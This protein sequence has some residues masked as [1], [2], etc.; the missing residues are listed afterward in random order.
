MGKR[1]NTA[2]W[3]EDQKRWRIKVQKNGKRKAFYSSIPGRNGQREANKKADEWL[4]FDI[5]YSTLKISSLWEDFLTEKKNITSF[6]NYRQIESLGRLYILPA[7]GN[8]K[9]SYLTEQHLQDIINSAWDKSKKDGKPFS[10]K[11]LNNLRN[12]IINFIKF[13]RK[14]S[15]TALF[16]EN[17]LIPF[18][19]ENKPKKILQKNDI[20]ILFTSD[21]TSYKGKEIVDPFINAYRFQVA[22]GLRPGELIALK[23]SDIENN[24][25]FLKRSI[26]FHGEF[27]NGK[28]KNAKRNFYLTNLDLKILEQQRKISQSEYIFD[29]PVLTT[30]KN[31]QKYY[32]DFWKRYQKYN[33]ITPV[34]PYELRHTFVSI[35]QNLPESEI[36]KIVGHSKN[37]DTFG[38]YAHNFNNKEKEISNKINNVFSDVLN[39]LQ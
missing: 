31:C 2:K 25:I 16:P 12:C 15:A 37:M 21:K 39:I 24:Q 32:F 38:V 35:I 1:V 14:K 33:N 6:S 22:T 7:I 36:K 9:M 5:D 19:A 18:S 3:I 27:T 4:D 29:I 8:K 20:Q 13:C 17:L 30:L 28:N 23:W 34:S 11:Y 10:K 26:N